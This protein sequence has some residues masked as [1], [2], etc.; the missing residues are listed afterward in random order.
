MIYLIRSLGATKL[1]L[2]WS[3][4]DESFVFTRRDVGSTTVKEVLGKEYNEEKSRLFFWSKV[5][6]ILDRL[7]MTREDLSY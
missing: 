1:M 7:G 2:Y 5:D 6:S 3:R 4:F